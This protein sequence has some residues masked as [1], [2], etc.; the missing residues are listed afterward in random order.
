MNIFCLFCLRLLS[1][2]KCSEIWLINLAVMFDDMS[3][4]KYIYLSTCIDKIEKA[5]DKKTP[6]KYNKIIK[7]YICL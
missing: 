7:R 2:Q 1:N 4:A 6:D 3:C 5:H